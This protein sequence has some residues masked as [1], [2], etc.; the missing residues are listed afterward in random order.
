MASILLRPTLL[1]PLLFKFL[2]L[3]L[4]PIGVPCD[5]VV[6][7]EQH[8]LWARDVGSVGTG[9]HDCPRSRFNN[10]GNLLHRIENL[11]ITENGLVGAELIKDGS[12]CCVAIQG[13]AI[14]YN[15]S[16]GITLPCN[17]FIVALA[18][19]LHYLCQLL[20]GLPGNVPHII[21]LIILICCLVLAEESQKPGGAVIGRTCGKELP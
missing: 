1:V 14:R 8:P 10:G 7:F 20:P 16:E 5:P 6:L 15:L 11:G 13:I 2:L 17:H 3:Q 18:T 21:A 4:Q 19:V 9:F 12:L